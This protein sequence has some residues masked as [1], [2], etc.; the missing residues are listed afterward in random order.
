ME[1]AVAVLVE[2]KWEHK[3]PDQLLLKLPGALQNA[4]SDL[5]VPSH[6]IRQSILTFATERHALTATCSAQPDPQLVRE[7][8]AKSET[9]GG[10][11]RV[12]AVVIADPAADRLPA[13]CTSVRRRCLR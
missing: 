13:G 8:T 3:R 7:E 5:G 12:S 10:A 11:F 2:I 1:G 9:E 6:P 4:P